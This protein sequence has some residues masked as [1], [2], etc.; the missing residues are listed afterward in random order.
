MMV[1]VTEDRVREIIARE[2]E[3]VKQETEKIAD[4]VRQLMKKHE[5]LD[6]ARFANVQRALHRIETLSCEVREYSASAQTNAAKIAQMIEAWNNIQ[7]FGHTIAWIS[8][9]IKVVAVPVAFVIA[10]VTLVKTGQW[11]FKL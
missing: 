1:P 10:I 3:P 5:E 2:L 9:A 11:V 7:G 6:T 8:K 4:S